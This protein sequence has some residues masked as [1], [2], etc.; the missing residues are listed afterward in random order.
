MDC[1]QWKCQNIYFRDQHRFR[2]G[3]TE[4]LLVVLAAELLLVNILNAN[5]NQMINILAVACLLA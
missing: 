2:E 1:S 3:V 5:L 4:Y